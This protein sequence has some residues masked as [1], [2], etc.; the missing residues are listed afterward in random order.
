M[1]GIV[2]DY[3]NG[4]KMSYLKCLGIFFLIYCVYFNV[5]AIWKT[6]ENKNT[7]I[8]EKILIMVLSLS[9][10]G[11]WIFLLYKIMG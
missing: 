9:L 8:L 11:L 3:F 6:E 2:L 4:D 7:S 1:I 5:K 10:G